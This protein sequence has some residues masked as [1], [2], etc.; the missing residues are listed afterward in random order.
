MLS[1][2]DRTSY[3][4]MRTCPHCVASALLNSQRNFRVTY[5]LQSYLSSSE[6][7]LVEMQYNLAHEL[8]LTFAKKENIPTY[9]SMYAYSE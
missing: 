8:M 9:L 7:L 3:I 5:L 6:C 1:K 4:K 2:W